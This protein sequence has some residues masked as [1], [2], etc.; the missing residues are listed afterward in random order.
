MYP[1]RKREPEIV[2]TLTD[3]SPAAPPPLADPDTGAVLL[4]RLRVGLGDLLCSVPALRALR[5][6]RPDV[7]VTLLTWP[8]V[9]PVVSRISRYVDELLPFPGVD[10]IPER[11]PRRDQWTPFL[12]AA[13]ARRFDL[14]VQCY[15]D[16]AV[17]NRV[18]SAVGA[19]AVGGFAPTGWSPPAGSERLHLPYPTREHE[20]WRHLH[21]VE[22]LGVPLP[23][24]ADVMEIAVEEEDERS[25]AFLRTRHRLSPG[26]YVVLH[27]GASAATRRWPPAA[28]ADVADRLHEQ[29]LT[30]VL[31][32]QAG[33]S[34]VTS[35][36]LIRMQHPAVDLTG[37]TA[38]GALAVL[39][40]DSALLVSNDTGTAHL[41]AAVG[42]RTVVVF[43]PGDPRRWA[44]PGPRHA[45]LVPD[46]ACAPCPHLECPI[47]F[48]CS[49]ATTPQAVLD[50]ARTV[51]AA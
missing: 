9:E 22:Q 3:P 34:D 44:H 29:G 38:L 13:R 16:N 49:R 14:A 15:G 12:D 23:E 41:A 42:A 46:V 45:A 31:T 8:E 24:S 17:A 35:Q 43:Q 32:G 4:V 7:R 51:L 5:G 27:P 20:V 11:P 21:L 25:A 26:R 18:A 48:R 33:E 19:R 37:R 1:G 28:Y 39:L 40:R 6:A 47:D 30:V 2:T 10:G 36:V 50:A